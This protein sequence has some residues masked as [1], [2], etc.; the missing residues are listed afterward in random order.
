MVVEMGLVIA[1]IVRRG[2]GGSSDQPD[3]APVM[4]HRAEPP[5]RP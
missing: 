4:E 5:D 3:S 2:P 1:A